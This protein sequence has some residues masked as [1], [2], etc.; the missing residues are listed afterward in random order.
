MAGE[1]KNE[2]TV[3]PI[4][5]WSLLNPLSNQSNMDITSLTSSCMLQVRVGEVGGLTAGF[6]GG[7]FSP[8]GSS[9]LGHGYQGA[10]SLWTKDS[11]Q[12]AKHRLS[13][14]V[15]TS[16]CSRTKID[17]NCIFYR[18]SESHFMALFSATNTRDVRRIL[19][20]VKREEEARLSS[21]HDRVQ[22]I[23]RAFCV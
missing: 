17:L 12:V 10:F 19:V 23:S 2:M 7:V 22:P 13:Q 1:G 21:A 14:S 3:P 18:S 5:T 4:S 6:F 15:T 20:D 16:W 11:E 9:I 8:D